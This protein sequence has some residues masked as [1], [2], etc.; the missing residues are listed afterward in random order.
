MRTK[1]EM[2]FH[3]VTF[4]V[5][6]VGVETMAFAV[7][8]RGQ[9]N[10]DEIVSVRGA[11][12]RERAIAELRDLSAEDVY[13][14]VRACVRDGFAFYAEIARRLESAVIAERLRADHIVEL[15]VP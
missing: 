2:T 6:T 9:H 4:V 11:D 15:A 7:D 10:H 3:G 13:R 8:S 1:T 12:S 14:H 5:S